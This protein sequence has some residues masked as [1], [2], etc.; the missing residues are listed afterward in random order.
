MGKC[1]TNGTR[2]I[3][4][5]FPCII[6]RTQTIV[7][8]LTEIL[9]STSGSP[10]VVAATTPPKIL[11]IFKISGSPSARL[12]VKVFHPPYNHLHPVDLSPTPH[13]LP[14]HHDPMSS[15]QS[16]HMWEGSSSVRPNTLVAVA[17]SVARLPCIC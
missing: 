11:G 15:L 9:D 2:G 10:F 1:N 16:H 12:G 13:E 8:I 14:R 6:I 3:G 7:V 5:I 17:P 4:S